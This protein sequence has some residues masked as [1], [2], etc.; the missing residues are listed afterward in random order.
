M[1]A[2]KMQKWCQVLLSPHIA[3]FWGRIYVWY[4]ILLASM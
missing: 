4:I 3:Y 2:S 1:T